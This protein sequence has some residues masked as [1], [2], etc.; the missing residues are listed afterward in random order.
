MEARFKHALTCTTGCYPRHT[1]VDCFMIW[2]AFLLHLVLIHGWT[3]VF[4]GDKSRTDEHSLFAG[5]LP[6][7]V[8]I[9]F[10]SSHM[11]G[12]LVVLGVQGGEV[13]V[14]RDH[15]PGLRQIDSGKTSVGKG[16]ITCKVISI[17]C[18]VSIS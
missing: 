14:Q 2:S 6:L 13:I 17:S 16:C 7:I 4:F 18:D 15:S 10:T 5:G 3:Q 9:P 12:Q 1:K 8:V 11:V